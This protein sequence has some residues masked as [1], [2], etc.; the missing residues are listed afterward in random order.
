VRLGRRLTWACPPPGVGGVSALAARPF[1]G[2]RITHTLTRF[3]VCA[4][5]QILTAGPPHRERC[6]GDA[7]PREHFLSSPRASFVAFFFFDGASSSTTAR[8]SV[9]SEK[10]VS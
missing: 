8:E 5:P 3:L 7:S 10:K 2:F 9:S 6:G 1:R 4:P